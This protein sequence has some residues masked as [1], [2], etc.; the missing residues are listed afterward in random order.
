[1]EY[2]QLIFKKAFARAWT[3]YGVI[4]AVLATLAA[5]VWG[6]NAPTQYIASFIMAAVSIIL[7]TNLLFLAPYKLWV[8]ERAKREALEKP[9]V[10]S[11]KT[12]R[13]QLFEASSGLLTSTKAI[14]HEWSVSDV[15]KRGYLTRDYHAKHFRMSSLA[16]NF[17]HEDDIY[18]AAQDAMNRCN[19]AKVDATEGLPN[20]NALQEAHEF[21][22]IL[23]LLLNAY[24]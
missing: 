11:L 17:L 12:R 19:I 2:L 21:T 23:L 5:A 16:D 14:F 20:H 24:S 13:N 7:L 15:H 1:M 9:D 3:V 18:R 10:D 6:D 4:S 22:K 8:E